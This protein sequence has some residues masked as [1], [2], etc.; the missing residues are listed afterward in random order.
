MVAWLLLADARE[1][2]G[3]QE[4]KH[5]FLVAGVIIAAVLLVVAMLIHVVKTWRKRMAGRPMTYPGEQLSSFRAL[6]E[7]GELSREEYERIRAKLGQ[8]LRKALEVPGPAA[9]PAAEA[10][11]EAQTPPAPP[12]EGPR[13]PSD[14]PAPGVNGAS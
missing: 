6:Y 14:P 13:P 5:E 12:A 11:A 1:N 4:W 9:A 3:L 7:R 10:T 8:K 2:A